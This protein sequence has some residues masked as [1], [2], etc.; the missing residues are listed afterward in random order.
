VRNDQRLPGSTPM[1]VVSEDAEF[2]GARGA[3]VRLNPLANWNRDRVRAYMEE[4]QVPVN[5]LRAQGFVAIGCEPCTRPTSE[6]R[7]ERDGL[8]WWERPEIDEERVTAP[9]GDGI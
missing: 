7:P 6:A 5:E 3:P 9:V 1:P 4:R 8:W 2:E